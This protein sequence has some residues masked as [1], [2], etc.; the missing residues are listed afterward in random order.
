MKVR[1]DA[2]TD[3]DDLLLL[4]LYFVTFEKEVLN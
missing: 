4:K 3:E 2:W 1:Q